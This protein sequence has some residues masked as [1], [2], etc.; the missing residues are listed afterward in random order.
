MSERSGMNS[1]LRRLVGISGPQLTPREMLAA[2]WSG[3][4]PVMAIIGTILCAVEWWKMLTG[5]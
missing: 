4:K 2:F 5:K 1:K 3:Y